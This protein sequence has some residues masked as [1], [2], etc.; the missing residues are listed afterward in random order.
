MEENKNSPD[1]TLNS[2]WDFLSVLPNLATQLDPSTFR[3]LFNERDIDV[4]ERG[5]VICT[6]GS[7]SDYWYIILEGRVGLFHDESNDVQKGFD[8]LFQTYTP[9][10]VEEGSSPPIG[11]GEG[12]IGEKRTSGWIRSNAVGVAQSVVAFRKG[13]RKDNPST[14]LSPEKSYTSDTGAPVQEKSTASLDSDAG[15][16]G[17]NI[18]NTTYGRGVLAEVE[19]AGPGGAGSG[20]PETPARG[21]P[22][23][24]RSNSLADVVSR[25]SRSSTSGPSKSVTDPKRKSGFAYSGAIDLSL[26][27]TTMRPEAKVTPRP[28]ENSSED[29]FA[30]AAKME[31]HFRYVAMKRVCA[32]CVGIQITSLSSDN[33]F[34]EAALSEPSL[35]TFVAMTK[36]YLVAIPKE[37]F[38]AAIEKMSHFMF[39]PT[40]TLRLLEKDPEERTS[41]ELH[42]IAKN[43]C[44]LKSFCMM[45]ITDVWRLAGLMRLLDVP[46][47]CKIYQQGHPSYGL[48]V[49][50]LGSANVHCKLHLSE[51]SLDLPGSQLTSPGPTAPTP[52]KSR[53]ERRASLLA[54][55]KKTLPVNEKEAVMKVETVDPDHILLNFGAYSGTDVIQT[56]DIFGEKEEASRESSII[57]RQPSKILA[58]TT[59]QV[60]EVHHL[61]RLSAPAE[62]KD[63]K[64][65]AAILE[66]LEGETG[67][68]EVADAAKLKLMLG[69]TELFQSLDGD[70][71]AE[72]CQ[73]ARLEEIPQNTPVVQQGNEVSKWCF[74][75]DG[76][77]EVMSN[78][79]THLHNHDNW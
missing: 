17:I 3:L 79:S 33:S 26:S 10:V 2:S 12:G 36:T 76:Y 14:S 62:L 55:M 40:E 13:L 34:A 66:V 73:Y 61:L 45:P 24:S 60:H 65:Q 54:T 25:I 64:R 29:A 67:M 37:V 43:I 38:Q 22:R 18:L 68:R 50:L 9:T 35:L 41:D 31:E 21:R 5:D 63:H 7:Q 75:M 78:E 56:G 19:K 39:A 53:K 8:R 42:V 44:C 57:T 58:L 48:Y 28:A 15:D 27:E 52:K 71:R 11:E 23:L 72:L 16:K 30:A 47:S 46:V 51:S 69:H 49:M 70:M 74:I 1:K 20:S 77:V 32:A 59:A 6:Q 4:R